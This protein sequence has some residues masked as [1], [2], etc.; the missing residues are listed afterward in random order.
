MQL[1]EYYRFG[2]SVCFLSAY[3]LMLPVFSHAE[4]GC[5]RSALDWIETIEIED[6]TVLKNHALT[7][8]E[9]ADKWIS[10][11]ED[12]KG[13]DRQRLCN[14]LVLIWTYKE[15]IYFRDYIHDSTY[16]PCKAWSR[17]MFQHCID[18]ENKWFTR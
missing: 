4:S 13:S 6:H 15:C 16:D 1:T 10:D 5:Y 18:H 11:F 8:C 14:D 17:E 2:L 12:R 9:F 3:C 7:K